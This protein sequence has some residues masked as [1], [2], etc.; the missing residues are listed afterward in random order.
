MLVVVA[1]ISDF[2]AGGPDAVPPEVAAVPH[3]A[4]KTAATHAKT[5]VSVL[6]I[7][8]TPSEVLQSRAK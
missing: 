2:T 4:S 5:T 3:P 6:R 1:K 7:T 8:V